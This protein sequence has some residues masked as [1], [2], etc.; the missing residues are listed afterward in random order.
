MIEMTAN[1]SSTAKTAPCA[2]PGLDRRPYLAR[3]D[4]DGLQSAGSAHSHAGTGTRRRLLDAAIDLFASQGYNAC[5]MREIAKAVNIGAPAIYNYYASKT[6]LLIA[7]L[8]FVL[9]TFYGAVLKNPIPRNSEAAL[10]A[11][12]RRHVLFGIMNRTFARAADALLNKE[13]MLR[14]LPLSHRFRYS[15][16]MDEYRNILEELIRDLVGNKAAVD[17]ALLAFLVHEIV[18]RAGEWYEPASPLN[19][20]DVADQCCEAVARMLGLPSVSK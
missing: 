12:L 3:L 1:K 14:E 6:D 4:L 15:N 8:D 7:S 11:I 19:P 13:L 18:D 5:S 20:A 2:Q 10:F 9:S 16:A 17:F